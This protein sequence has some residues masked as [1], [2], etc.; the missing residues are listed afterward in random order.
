MFHK[1]RLERLACNKHSNLLGLLLRYD[2]NECCK[3]GTWSQSY[4]SFF[5]VTDEE[6]K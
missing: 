3:Y 2:E 1:T 4:K 5:F 6:A